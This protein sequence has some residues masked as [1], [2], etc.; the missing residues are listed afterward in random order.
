MRK[1]WIEQGVVDYEVVRSTVV[2]PIQIDQDAPASVVSRVE[3]VSCVMMSEIF[4][5]SEI[6]C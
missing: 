3:R 2:M 6:L 1:D 4:H 5:L